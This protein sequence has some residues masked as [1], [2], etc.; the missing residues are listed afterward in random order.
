MANPTEHGEVVRT[1]RF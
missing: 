1:C